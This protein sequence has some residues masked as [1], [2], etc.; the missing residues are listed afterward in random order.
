MAVEK[1]KILNGICIGL[2]SGLLS[3]AVHQIGWFELLEGKTWDW[4]A[5]VFAKPSEATDRIRLI[6]VDQNSLDWAREQNGLTWPWPRE[7]Y[8]AVT[9]YCRRMGA[10]SLAFDVQYFEP[11]LYG[12]EDDRRFAQA[13]RGFENIVLPV[14]LG[15]ETGAF[16]SWPET[17]R[18]PASIAREDGRLNP[19]VYPRAI[20]PIEPLLEA[21]PLLSN[22]HLQPDA[23]GV[24][25]RTGCFAVFDG[26]ALPSLGLG[27]FLA[28]DAERRVELDGRTMRIGGRNIRMSDDSTVILRYRGPSGT[29]RAYS[30]AAVIQSA[31]QAASGQPTTIEDPD[32]FRDRYVFFGFSAPGLF[33]LRSSP[34]DGVYPGVEIHATFLDNLLVGDFIRPVPGSATT[35]AAL[36]LAAAFSVLLSGVHSPTRALSLSLLGLLLPAGLSLLAYGMGY[37]LPVVVLEASVILTLVAAL[38]VYYATE[39]R[40]KRFIKSAFR[41][42][43]S[44][45]VIEELLLH[46]EKL[47][48]GGERRT[49]SI[50]FS[51][52]QGFTSISESLSPEELTLLLNDYLT[53]MTDIIHEERGTVDKYEGDAIIAFW[54]AP[55]E[56]P[57]HAR[58]A[59]SAALRCQ[60]R[61]SELRPD[62]RRRA[63]KDLFMRIGINSGPAVVGNMG[64]NTRFDYTML[65]DAV[66]LAA[67]L[68]GANK[69]FGTYTMISDACREQLGDAFHGRELAR[70]AVVGRKEPVAVYEPFSAEAYERYLD[71]ITAFREGLSLYYAGRWDEAGR[72][73]ARI[74]DR[75]P[76][77]AAYEKRCRDLCAA[78]PDR[79]DGVW[80]M[81]QK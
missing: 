20:F 56:V 62:F 19:P 13:I 75:D 59:V 23:D 79:F 64:S 49:L 34:V 14:F 69:Q 30:A 65:G 81:T 66:N 29:H 39:G 44:P 32:A 35:A 41:Q 57:G 12:V 55:L 36:L 48:L 26:R 3:L 4:R 37:W 51:D 80:F 16:T 58:R 11:S 50:F 40:K 2:A 53:A 33:D 25:R 9:D 6:L 1:R 38:S 42:Y 7:I 72:V 46:P 5:S 43:L 73:F 10:K 61:L 74:A 77:S 68:E 76:P 78:P 45:D 15:R 31:M 17:A 70:L 18:P 63:G 71:R 52:L 28:A 22:V 8:R 27:A 67:R 24:Y 21:R 60:Q 54:N 47:Q